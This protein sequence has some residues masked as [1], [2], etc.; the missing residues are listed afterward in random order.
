MD[1]ADYRHQPILVTGLY[2]KTPSR[3]R[4]SFDGGFSLPI[5]MNIHPGASVLRDGYQ[6]IFLELLQ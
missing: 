6:A 2:S 3:G 1:P 4:A 5:H